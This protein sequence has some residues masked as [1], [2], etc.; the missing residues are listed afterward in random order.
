M[1]SIIKERTLLLR[2]V[3]C[4]T[5]R[6]QQAHP[7]VFCVLP[8]EVRNTALTSKIFVLFCSVTDGFMDFCCV[9]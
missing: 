6:Y 4:N 9:L 3:H 1:C 8:S 5:A 2:T 7:P